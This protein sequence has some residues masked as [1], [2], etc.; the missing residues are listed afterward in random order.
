MNPGPVSSGQHLGTWGGG[1][2]KIRGHRSPHPPRAVSARPTPATM[3]MLL[4]PGTCCGS[5]QG[6][7]REVALLG[8]GFPT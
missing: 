1:S 8:L 3:S 6:G 7:G 4:L 5:W 2:G